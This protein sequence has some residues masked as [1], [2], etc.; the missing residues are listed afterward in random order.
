MARATVRTLIPLDNVAKIVGIDPLHFNS[1]TLPRAYQAPEGCD[2]YWYQHEYQ[3]SGRF[4]RESLALVLNEAEQATADLLGYY[5]LPKWISG[6]EIQIAPPFIPEL[7]RTAEYNARGDAI[8]VRTR[9]KHVLAGGIVGKTL[10]EAN[11]AVAYSD[12]DSDG[13]D[14][15]ATVTVSTTVTDREEIRVFFPGTDGDDSWEI[16]PVDVSID[17]TTSTATLTFKKA[18][19]VLP[20][21]QEAI[22]A[23]DDPSALL[24]NGEENDNFLTVV[25]VWRVYEDSSQQAVLYYEPNV[26]GT[27]YI[28][29]RDGRNGV[30]S[31][32][33]ATYADGTWTT[34]CNTSMPHKL[35]LYYRAGLVNPDSAYPH[36]RMSAPLEKLIVNYALS[37]ADKKV[38]GCSNIN[39]WL[40]YQS[41]DLAAIKPNAATASY[42]NTEEILNCPLG[43]T[44]A[45]LNLWRYIKQHRQ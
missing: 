38:C 12:A 16:R 22:A 5:P 23:P 20:E 27:A 36:L 33:P 13:Y 7:R 43:T 28:Y 25:D 17:T 21:L 19:A 39:N 4:S 35:V 30:V 8:S 26:T 14:E 31:Y 24:V 3:D 1:I 9:Y 44:R 15:T 11:A 6:E 10:I 42:Q 41:E 37:L 18:L 45:A 32:Y 40:E 2:D 29:V 34:T